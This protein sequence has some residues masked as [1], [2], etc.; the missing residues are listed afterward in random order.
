MDS[1]SSFWIFLGLVFLAVFLL[2][3]GLVVPVFGEST[4]MRKRL[5]SRLSAVGT[6][7][8]QPE[9]GSLLREKYLREL[10]PLERALET[11]PGMERL[12]RLI[13]QS[14]K[15]TPAYRVLLVSLL[16]AAAGAFVGWSYTRLIY[17][18]L[19]GAGGGF[20]LPYIKVIA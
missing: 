13:E 20:S 1:L 12:G 10:S 2:A 5:L 14:G 3:Q 6:A 19:L 7:S 15:S 8:G 11:L 18:M 17:C 9:F 16:F 4:R